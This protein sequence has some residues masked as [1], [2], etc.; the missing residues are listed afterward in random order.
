MSVCECVSA[1]V[2]MDS[3]CRHPA[4][5]MRV[6][7][8]TLS[9]VLIWNEASQSQPGFNLSVS[10]SGVGEAGTSAAAPADVAARLDALTA[11]LACYYFLSGLCNK[12]K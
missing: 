11:L 10:E 7:N 8:V 6:C 1:S 9:L 12:L 5:V 4:P 3:M 2:S